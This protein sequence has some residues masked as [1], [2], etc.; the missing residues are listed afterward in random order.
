MA[1]FAADTLRDE[2]EQK[3]DVERIRT[4]VRRAEDLTEDGAGAIASSIDG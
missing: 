1:P 2:T 4:T 3:L